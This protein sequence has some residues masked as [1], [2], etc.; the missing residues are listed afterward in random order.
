MNL[1]AEFKGSVNKPVTISDSRFGQRK[2]Y[3]NQV[4]K[5]TVFVYANPNRGWWGYN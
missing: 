4:D 5:P 2:I 1:S 3:L